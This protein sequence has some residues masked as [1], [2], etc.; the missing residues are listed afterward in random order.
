MQGRRSFVFV[1]DANLLPRFLSDWNIE[2]NINCL[3]AIKNDSP[4]NLPVE[5]LLA[6]GFGLQA[7]RSRAV[8]FQSLM[9]EICNLRPRV[10]MIED[11]LIMKDCAIV[12][13]ILA[14]DFDL[15]VVVV[16]G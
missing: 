14:M 3:I 5:M 4:L 15:K 11:A 16:S 7:V 2:V 1:H 10:V 12:T 6:H 8:D 9:D 13:K